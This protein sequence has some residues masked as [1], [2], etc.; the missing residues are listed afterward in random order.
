ME[1]RH[2]GRRDRSTRSLR[3]P[4]FGGGLKIRSGIQIEQIAG[5]IDL[6][7]MEIAQLKQDLKKRLDG[8]S[9]LPLL[10]G[11]KADW[12]PRE[13]FS[14]RRG[15]VS[16]RSQNFRLDSQGKLFDIVTDRGQKNDVSVRYP[17]VTSKLKYLAKQHHQEME[18][19]FAKNRERPFSVGFGQSTML[20]ARDGIEHGNISRSVKS[21][22]NS[23][24]TNWKDAGDSIPGR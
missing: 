1:W 9:L 2:E 15:A 24:F 8:R 6:T 4:L 12:K 5:A 18:A 23:F 21:P 16:V 20:P 11:S 17:Q 19:E 22:N 3:S 10:V 7:L 13:L 14:I